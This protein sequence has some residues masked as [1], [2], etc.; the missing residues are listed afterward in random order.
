MPAVADPSNHWSWYAEEP[1]S[2]GA[3]LIMTAPSI[4]MLFMGQE[5]LEDKQW[6]DNPGY[7]QNTLIWWDGLQAGQKPMVDFLRFSQ[8]LI[9]LRRPPAGT[10][11]RGTQRVPRPQ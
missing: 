10:P 9:A 11:R 6:S 2:R 1:V 3:G 4:P 7:Y 5:F 8:E